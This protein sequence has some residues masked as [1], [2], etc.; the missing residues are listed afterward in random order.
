VTNVVTVTMNPAIDATIT[1]D[2]LIPG[3]VH[4]AKTVA[5]HAGGKGVNVAS[6]LA[7][8]GASAITAT[9]ILGAANASVFETLFAQKHI[10]D[11]FIRIPG[12]TRTNIKLS[13]AGETTDINLPGLAIDAAMSSKLRETILAASSPDSIVLLAGSLPAGADENFY[14]GLIAALNHIG[15]K[16]ILDTSGAPLAAALHAA[17]LPY[18]IKP[19]RAE[20]E[21]FTGRA[22][23]SDEDIITA[24]RTLN[25]G[26]IELVAVSLGAEGALFITGAK[27]LRASLPPI[28]AA[29]TV[30]AGDAMVA[31]MIA[32]LREDAGLERTARL[33]TAFAAAKLLRAGPNL[34]PRETIETLAAKVTI[35]T[36][37]GPGK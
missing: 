20:L 4:R 11:A 29:S 30:G 34:P 24:A 3:Q 15:A 8:W 26:G 25:A 27:I 16:I 12:E 14:S 6:C 23:P 33:A 28:T 7:D 13:H 22:L 35:K 19:N 17:A 31:G 9:G 37:G 5:F 2:A 10:I 36:M 32:A 1:L 18:A 21:A